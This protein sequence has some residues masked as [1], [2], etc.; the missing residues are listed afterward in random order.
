MTCE[1]TPEARLFTVLWI[2]FGVGVVAL[3]LVEIGSLVVDAR[4]AFA[5]KAR[6]AG[7]LVAVDRL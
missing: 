1:P 2:L 3:L 6:C 4:D 5:A 7:H